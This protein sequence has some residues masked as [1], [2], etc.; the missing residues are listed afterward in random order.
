MEENQNGKRNSS[1]STVYFMC[2]SHSAA[3]IPRKHEMNSYPRYTQ[4]NKLQHI[5]SRIFLPHFSF[6]FIFPHHRFSFVSKKPL[7]L[8]L[9]LSHTVFSVSCKIADARI[10][11][12]RPLRRRRLR[13]CV[14]ATS[15][16]TT[17]LRSIR[18]LSIQFHTVCYLI[19]YQSTE[20]CE[21][22]F[23]FWGLGFF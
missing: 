23:N 6:L 22:L 9:S 10:R 8:S 3:Y 1:I 2:C 4:T 5:T 16:T 21:Y 12:S 14:A 7:S 18:V 19:S 15:K 11:A 20:F 17:V 13:R